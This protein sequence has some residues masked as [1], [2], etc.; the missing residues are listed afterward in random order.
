[1]GEA[2][3]LK[4]LG[5]LDAREA[6]LT[7]ALS[8]SE[9]AP[10]FREL[11]QK[12]ELTQR[13]HREITG[14][15]T[16]EGTGLVNRKAILAYLTDFDGVLAHGSVSDVQLLLR[17]FVQTVEKGNSQVTIRYTL[18]L[19]PEKIPLD[20]RAVLDFDSYGGAIET[21]PHSTSGSLFPVG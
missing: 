20:L 2:N 13:L 9:L 15:L 12:R 10:R 3:T 17:S 1:M 18:P 4:A 5:D 19:P 21:F 16:A 7:E 8:L 6:R 11:Q 14:A